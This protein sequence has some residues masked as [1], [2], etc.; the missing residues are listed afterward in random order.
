MRV[1]K[2]EIDN[3][4][5]LYENLPEKIKQK[6]IEA[7]GLDQDA[8]TLPGLL[9]QLWDEKK[10]YVEMYNIEQYYKY[11]E[12]ILAKM[13]SRVLNSGVYKGKTLLLHALDRVDLEPRSL[14][15][16]LEVTSHIGINSI[17]EIN[18]KERS[19]LS[20]GLEKGVSFHYWRKLVR[21][22]LHDASPS[23]QLALDVIQ[24][25]C[26]NASYSKDF[27][28]DCQQCLDR[29]LS[30]ASPVQYPILGWL[31]SYIVSL[32]PKLKAV[33]VSDPR[34][35]DEILDFNTIDKEGYVEINKIQGNV[36]VWQIDKI[37]EL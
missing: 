14:G 29:M 35:L 9:F 20:V 32:V 28:I 25:K 27:L 16:I 30:A 18:G 8:Y 34:G 13:P 5:I 37:V 33:E 31:C 3:Y 10:L 12:E 24:K 4:E 19:A 22:P 26:V 2:E 1:T 15:L 21:F 11:F 36:F 23:L 7:S 6:W 17:F